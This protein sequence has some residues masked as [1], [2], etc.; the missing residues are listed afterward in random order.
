[1][2][3]RVCKGEGPGTHEYQHDWKLDDTRN[4]QRNLYR[5]TGGHSQMVFRNVRKRTLVTRFFRDNELALHSGNHHLV[6]AVN[7]RTCPMKQ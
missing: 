3:G 2:V 5:K 1:M 6:H 4:Q 7:V